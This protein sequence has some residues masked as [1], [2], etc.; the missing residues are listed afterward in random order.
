MN[1]SARSGRFVKQT[2]A[3]REPRTTATEH[4]GA[5]SGDH[6]VHRS[7]STGRFVRSTTAELHPATTE[8]QRV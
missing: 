1:R 5:G 4:V 3:E 2:T 7:T 6:V 8:T